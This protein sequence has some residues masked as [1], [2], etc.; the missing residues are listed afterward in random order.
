MIR[1]IQN[2]ESATRVRHKKKNATEDL[3]DQVKILKDESLSLQT[4]NASLS[5]ENMI[6]KQQI[7][8]YEKVLVNQQKNLQQPAHQADTF[9]LLAFSSSEYH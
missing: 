3:I 1:R 2:R 4:Q 8:F 9:S 6:L 7:M 5:T